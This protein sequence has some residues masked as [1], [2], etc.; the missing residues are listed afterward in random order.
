MLTGGGGCPGLIAVI[1]AVVRSRIDK[2]GDQLVGL[3][4]G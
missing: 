2:F 4:D 3:R 1:R